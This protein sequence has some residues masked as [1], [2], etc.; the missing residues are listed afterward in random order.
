MVITE[1]NVRHINSHR[2]VAFVWLS[3]RYIKIATANFEWYIQTCYSFLCKGTIPFP[4]RMSL[5]SKYTH[6]TYPIQKSLCPFFSSHNDLFSAYQET[7]HNHSQGETSKVSL[8]HFVNE[9]YNLQCLYFQSNVLI[10]FW[11]NET[12]TSHKLSPVAVWISM[13]RLYQHTYIYLH[14]YKAL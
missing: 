3:A 13:L 9:R 1:Q 6:V 14:G 5:E 7:K 2:N 10:I 11:E 8:I 12:A 4:R